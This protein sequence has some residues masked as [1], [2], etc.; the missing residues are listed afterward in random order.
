MNCPDCKR[1]IPSDARLC[2][3]CGVKIIFTITPRQHTNL[4]IISIILGILSATFWWIP[5]IITIFNKHSLENFTLNGWLVI[6]FPMTVLSITLGS[7]AFGSIAYIRT[8]DSYG[9]AG[10]TLGSAIIAIG[11]IFRIMIPL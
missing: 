1:E 9:L 4:G 10:L 3:Y 5:I 6:I 8:K 7:I 2:P 11:L